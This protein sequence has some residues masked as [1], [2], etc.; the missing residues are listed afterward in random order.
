MAQQ[1]EDNN[2]LD[3]FHQDEQLTNFLNKKIDQASVLEEM[4][5]FSTKDEFVAEHAD[6]SRYVMVD[7][8]NGVASKI[9]T[10]DL[11]IAKSFDLK[12]NDIKVMFPNERIL[13]QKMPKDEFYFSINDNIDMLDKIEKQE[14]KEK[15]TQAKDID[16][17]K[18]LDSISV[19]EGLDVDGLLDD[20]KPKKRGRPRRKI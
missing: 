7:F 11:D 2:T 12:I 4:Q 15:L 18:L 19:M 3:M 20:D 17:D 9:R 1:K 8:E 6:G 16:P 5:S 13:L 10:L 14:N